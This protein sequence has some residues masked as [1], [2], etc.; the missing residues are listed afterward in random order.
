MG[1]HPRCEALGSRIVQKKTYQK[2][3][4]TRL[5]IARERISFYQPRPENR[6]LAKRVTQMKASVH[7]T[8]PRP[9]AR[10]APPVRRSGRPRRGPGP[11]PA[12]GGDIAGAIPGAAEGAWQ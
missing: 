12:G 11:G 2:A 6:S 5:M 1:C 8:P 3:A 7:F 4:R 9:P 10:V